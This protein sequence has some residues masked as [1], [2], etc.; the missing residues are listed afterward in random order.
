[1]TLPS[2]LRVIGDRAFEEAYVTQINFPEGLVSIGESAFERNSLSSVTLPASLESL[3]AGA[4][5]HGQKLSQVS[6]I[7]HTFSEKEIENYFFNTP[8][9]YITAAGR[10][11]VPDTGSGEDPD[12]SSNKDPSSPSADFIIENGVL[13]E[14]SDT[15]VTIPDGVTVIG[16]GAFAE[17]RFMTRVILPAGVTRIEEQAFQRCFSLSPITLPTGLEYLWCEYRLYP[18]HD[19][20]IPLESGWKSGGFL[21]WKV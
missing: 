5:G 18:R 3:G 19:R 13:V 14:Y 7:G 16:K 9:Q 21:Q 4:F 12:T 2:T 8:F 6:W 10:G 1:M 20:G 17:Q 15:T 11:T